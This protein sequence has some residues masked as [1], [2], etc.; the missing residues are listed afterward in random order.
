MSIEVLVEAQV[1]N[2]EATEMN[3]RVLNNAL[4]DGLYS[5]LGN[6]DLAAEAALIRP[7]L[8]ERLS[9]SLD[10]S[11]LGELSPLQSKVYEALTKPNNYNQTVGGI[12]QSLGIREANFTRLRG[13]I[14]KH[15]GVRGRGQA[16]AFRLASEARDNN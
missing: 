12:A 4:L 9:T 15:L 11:G 3:G 7:E 2:P 5:R 16:V 13:K 6:Q 14:Y 8:L 1:T 10:F